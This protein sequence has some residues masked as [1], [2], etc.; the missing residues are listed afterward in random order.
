MIFL[1]ITFI[2]V[3]PRAEIVRCVAE[4]KRPFKIIKDCGFQSLMKTGRP[5]YQ[6]P[7][8][9]T[10]SRDVKKVFVQVRKLIAKMLQVCISSNFW[11]KN[12]EYSP[13][14]P[15]GVQWCLEFRN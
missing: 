1:Y 5:A 14:I 2:H 4:S 15:L 6:I 10:V 9:E 12:K 7:S 3:Y 8:P 11:P 13:E